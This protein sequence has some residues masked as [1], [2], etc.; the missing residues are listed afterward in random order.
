M[1]KSLFSLLLTLCL[2]LRA[3]VQAEETNIEEDLTLTN[4]TIQHVTGPLSYV[5]TTGFLP[6]Y[7]EE[8]KIAELFFIAYT[9]EGEKDRPIT[10]FFPGGP[11][12][13]GTVESI[14]TFGPRRLQTATEGR[15]ILPPYTLI[16]NPET[17]LDRTDL[18][19]VDPIN[20][21][22]SRSTDKAKLSQLYSVEGDIQTLGEFV[23]TYI[24][25]F[26]RWN[27][28]KYLAGGSYGTFRCAGLSHYLL[29]HDLQVHGMI[30][31]GC[32]IEWS[33]LD[34]ERDFALPDCLLIPTFAATAWYHKRLWPEKPLHEVLDFARRFA[35]EE[36]AP[37]MLQ[38][39]RLGKWEQEIFYKQLAEIIGLPVDTVKRYNGRINEKIF[40]SEFLAP[41]RKKLGGLDTRYSG[42]ISAI[43]VGCCYEDPSYSD[44]MGIEAAFKMYLRRELQTDDKLRPYIGFC[45]DAL[46]NWRT[47]TYDSQGKPNFLQRLRR[48]MILNPHLK[49]FVGSGYYD[50]RTPFAATEYCFEHLDLPEQYHKNLQF[51]YYDAGHGFILDGPCLKQMRQDLDAFYSPSPTK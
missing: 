29:W 5:A 23:R 47:S 26:D 42:D 4:H 40:T 36:Y 17:L 7:G 46:F 20:C 1:N 10:F 14:F 41:E 11:G 43:D 3:S 12:G 19:F 21:G 49:V 38:P 32:A 39:S 8:G 45:Y 28:P 24:S 16:D 51:A 31:H 15:T 30:L 9:K 48:V 33:S 35:Y 50:C 6:L 22:Y 25:Y 44:S 13:A 27:C 37:F 2:C 18:V 34:S